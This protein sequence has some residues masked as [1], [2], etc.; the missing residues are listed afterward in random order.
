MNQEFFKSSVESLKKEEK[1]KSNNMR[2]IEEVDIPIKRPILIN[3]SKTPSTLGRKFHLD[4]SRKPIKSF[5]ENH[6]SIERNI[7][8]LK[9]NKGVKKLFNLNKLENN[10]SSKTPK[11]SCT[12]RKMKTPFKIR[13]RL[14]ESNESYHRSR[15]S[16]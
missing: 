12:L 16:K 8:R 10:K 6:Q 14:T 11:L 3:Y 7:K 4:T 5:F 1:R 2:L 9:I 15:F 13:S